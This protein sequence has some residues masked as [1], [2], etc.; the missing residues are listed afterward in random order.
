[1]IDQTQLKQ[2]ATKFQTNEYTILR[3]YVQI[4]FLDQFYQSSLVKGTYFKGGTAIR[5]LLG[6]PRFSEDLDFSSKQTPPNLEA[7]VF[8]T[9]KALNTVLPN[10]KVKNLETLQGYSAKLYLSTTISSQPLTVKLD[11]SLRGN[12]LETLTGAVE[13]I[14]PVKIISV[15]DHLSPKELLAEK[16]HAITNRQKG[17]DVFDLWFLLSKNISFDQKFINKKLAFFDQKL[18]I[19]NLI[20]KINNW[21]DKNLDADLR[22]FLSSGDR[23]IIT[24]LKRIITEKLEK[25]E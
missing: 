3:E 25:Y 6:S 19:R 16:I 11:F 1:M 17:R 23:K 24:E 7:A 14:L 13:T 9:V 8:S 10:L 22:P 5:L 20:N 21:P 18:N 2:L 12:I 15:V 4:L